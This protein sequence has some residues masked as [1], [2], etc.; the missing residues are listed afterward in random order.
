MKAKQAIIIPREKFIITAKI[1][2]VIHSRKDSS[3]PITLR[4]KILIIIMMIITFLII[5]L[6]IQK[7]SHLLCRFAASFPAANFFQNRSRASET[8]TLEK[9]PKNPRAVIK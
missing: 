7:A 6:P 5:Y 9:I 1:T 2:L 4:P 8:A 3:F